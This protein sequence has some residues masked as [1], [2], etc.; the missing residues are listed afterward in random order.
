MDFT[1]NT[2]FAISRIVISNVPPPRSKTAILL[3]SDFVEPVGERSCRGL[4]N[5][6]PYVES[7][8]AARVLCRL[9]LEVVEMCRAQ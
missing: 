5:Y 3:F 6:A 2:P 8:Y 9:P 7:G 4:V 1:S